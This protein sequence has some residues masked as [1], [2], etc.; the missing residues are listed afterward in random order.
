MSSREHQEVSEHERQYE[1]GRDPQVL[2]VINIPLLAHQPADY[3]QENWLLDPVHYWTKVR[4]ATPHELEGLLE[5]FGPLWIDGYSTY[6]GINDKVPIG[7]ARQLGSSL[8]LIRVNEV[9]LSVF[10][11]AFGQQK[12]KV[13]AQFHYGGAQYA[14]S[15]TDPRYEREYLARA[16][17][18]Y[19]LDSC[20][21]TISLGEAFQGDSYKLVAAIL[22][23]PD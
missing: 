12:R 22:P 7:L 15:V 16:D 21:L 13:Q 8:R 6:N 19:Q 5:P 1:D 2:D 18:E 3:Q 4:A 20:Y 10:K 17:G 9:V 11:S 14:L 23:L